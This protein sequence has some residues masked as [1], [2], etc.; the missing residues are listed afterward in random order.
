[1]CH[2]VEEHKNAISAMKGLVIDQTTMEVVADSYG[3][4]EIIEADTIEDEEESFTLNEKKFKSEDYIFY[5]TLNGTQIR[6]F[7]YAGRV[8]V[9][10][11]K[12]LNLEKSKWTANQTFKTLYEEAR[13]GFEIFERC[14]DDTYDRV[15]C[16]IMM[17]QD[18]MTTSKFVCTRPFLVLIDDTTMVYQKRPSDFDG[19]FRASKKFWCE[20]AHSRRV[21]RP[22]HN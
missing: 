12:K 11:Q 20:I 15:F 6:T 2:Y 1:M 7:K 13:R 3:T 14:N 16:F 5:P 4:S 19:R 10:S 17:V 8:W 22:E 21:W 9:V 18:M